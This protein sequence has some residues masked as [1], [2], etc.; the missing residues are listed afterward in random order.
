MIR[1]ENTRTYAFLKSF[2]EQIIHTVPASGKLTLHRPVGGRPQVKCRFYH[3]QEAFVIAGILNF[4]P[5]LLFVKR[6]PDNNSRN[7]DNSRT[8][9]Y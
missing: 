5:A 7:N 9:G 8:V 3:R 6:Q 4:C 1:S 2:S